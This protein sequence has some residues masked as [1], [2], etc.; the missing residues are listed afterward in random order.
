MQA[1]V[2]GS[3]YAVRVVEGNEDCVA[4]AWGRRMQTR[5][6]WGAQHT[7]QMTMTLATGGADAS[8]G[9]QQRAACLG[10]DDPRAR[11][12]GGEE[13]RQQGSGGTAWRRQ[14]SRG[15]ARRRKASGI[16][17]L[18]A[19]TPLPRYTAWIVDSDN[20]GRVD[21]YE[22]AEEDED[23]ERAKRA[24]ITSFGEPR[25]SARELPFRTFGEF[26]ASHRRGPFEGRPLRDVR[27]SA[28]SYDRLFC[29]VCR[30]FDCELHGNS[31]A[32]TFKDLTAPFALTTLPQ[33]P[34]APCGPHCHVLGG[35]AAG[36]GKRAWSDEDRV[37]AAIA[38]PL[39]QYDCCLLASTLQ[40]GLR[41]CIELHA[42]MRHLHQEGV[43][44]GRTGV[45]PSNPRRHA[46]WL[47][48]ER[49]RG[50]AAGA[51]ATSASVR[52]L[53][54]QRGRIQPGE[55]EPYHPCSCVG[56][57]S[58]GS[59][60][61]RQGN[62]FCEKQCRCSTDCCNFFPGCHCRGPCTLLT[63]LCM[64]AHRECDPD[65]CGQCKS[66]E[67]GSCRNM[68]MALRHSVQVEVKPSALAGMGAYLLGKARRG[69][70]VGEYTGEV[71][72]NDDSGSKTYEF[73]L[74][75][76]DVLDAE[77]KGSTLK[78]ANHS[79]SHAN[80]FCKVVN[81]S[82]V[83]RV[84]IFAL[85]SLRAGE[86]VLYDYCSANRRQPLFR[87]KEPPR[88]GGKGSSDSKEENV[89]KEAIRRLNRLWG[90]EDKSN[91][92]EEEERL[93]QDFTD[94]PPQDVHLMAAWNR[95]LRSL[96][97]KLPDKNHST[98]VKAFVFSE[99]EYLQLSPLMASSLFL[100]LGKLWHCRLINS[101][102]IL[103][104]MHIVR[105]AG[106]C[107]HETCVGLH[108]VCLPGSL[109]GE[110]PAEAFAH[111]YKRKRALSPTPS[112]P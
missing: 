104:C 65:I 107:K 39:L 9:G 33:P 63:C 30:R 73:E 66:T 1:V 56:P 54:Q 40:R 110:S 27:E 19:L 55:V 79:R 78:F 11:E 76:T 59:C 62:N 48:A 61:C 41:T 37:M 81:V 74:T 85:R 35:G 13:A 99:C 97:V 106:Q 12:T 108:N 98:V 49:E 53:M 105:T 4:L 89:E 5:G 80:C 102:D 2:A 52:A 31:L 38:L 32:T 34:A 95:L 7:A 87:V 109:Q 103:R 96:H 3:D 70:L 47:E 88:E 71:V 26:E 44:E 51:A 45:G 42:L 43:A 64:Q 92:D 21:M 25:C 36:Q 112:A 50:G 90:S 16:T 46:W 29:C 17:M 72:G 10:E 20:G 57:C 69:E 86:E 82:G 84:G 6:G 68:Q 8:P 67:P 83:P 91:V 94:V 18:P 75:S 60:A 23:E 24:A 22:K 100:F 93:L 58:P 14:A 77:H 111:A 28:L 101:G 15:K